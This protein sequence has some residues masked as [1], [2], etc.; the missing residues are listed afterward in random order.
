[1]DDYLPNVPKSDPHAKPVEPV[2]QVS[3]LSNGINVVTQDTPYNA[4]SHFGIYVNSGSRYE[5]KAESGASHFLQR[6]GFKVI[7]IY[8]KADSN[9]AYPINLLLQSCF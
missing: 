8:I 3:K 4:M 2:V 1:M 6:L 7:Y 9:F 5:T